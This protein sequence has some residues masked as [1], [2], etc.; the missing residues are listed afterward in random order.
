VKV[1]ALTAVAAQ[2]VGPTTKPAPPPQKSGV[3]PGTYSAFPVTFY[4]P[5]GTGSVLNFSNTSANGVQ[6]N[7]AGGGYYLTRPTILKTP[8]KQDQ[9]FTAKTS[10]SG[11]VG[12]ANATITYFVTG[13]F[14]GPNA[15]GAATAA[16]VFRVDIVFADTP[17]RKCTSNDQPWTAARSG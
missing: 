11:V 7:C 2:F 9:S 13:Y 5:A 15:K 3:E 6:V 17:N 4:V 8:I 16:G 14:Q 1:S 12:G 10:E